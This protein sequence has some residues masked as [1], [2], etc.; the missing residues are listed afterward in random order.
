[1]QVCCWFGSCGQ[2]EAEYTDISVN[3]VLLESLI[4]KYTFQAQF[5]KNYKIQGIIINM[6]FRIQKYTP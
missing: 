1:M 6:P 2:K 3:K 4:L 5:F